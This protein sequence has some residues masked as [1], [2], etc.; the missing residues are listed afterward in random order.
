MDKSSNKTKK[1]NK[2]AI[3]SQMETFMKQ[4]KSAREIAIY[5]TKLYQTYPSY[6]TFIRNQYSTYI[7]SPSISKGYHKLIKKKIDGFLRMNK[8]AKEI[9]VFFKQLH[10]IYPTHTDYIHHL[11]NERFPKY[12]ITHSALTD[13][14][15]PSD[16]CAI[17]QEPL[18]NAEMKQIKCNHVYHKNC[19]E[20]WA[21]QSNLCPLCRQPIR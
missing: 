9:D 4:N 1:L 11:F 19:I 8:S 6:I 15:I 18:H 17:C 16:I 12:Y 10:K 14:N 13:I 7:P 21:T 5:L 20:E 3:K 2:T